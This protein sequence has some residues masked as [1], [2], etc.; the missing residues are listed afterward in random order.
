MSYSTKSKFHKAET[1]S[2][3][4]LLQSKNY[5]KEE[6]NHSLKKL[7]FRMNNFLDSEIQSF[8]SPYIQQ[9]H[10]NCKLIMTPVP[11]CNFC[12]NNSISFNTPDAT[13]EK[14]SKSLKY[15]PYKDVAPFSFEE[16]MVHLRFYSPLVLFTEVKRT[17]EISHWGNILVDEYYNLFNE[18]A[19]IKGEFGRVDY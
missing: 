19:G 14:K 15:G 10:K 16:V 17:I 18:G 13:A 7:P 3:S 9:D 2:L 12:L 11:S 1:K 8:S 5:T 4:L 6:R